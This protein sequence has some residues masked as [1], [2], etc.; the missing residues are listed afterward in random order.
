MPT[1]PGTPEL[2]PTERT[3]V[4]RKRERGSYDVETIHAILDEGMVCHVGFA[5]DGHPW[6]IPTAYARIGDYVYLHGATA[7]N[8]LRTLA[9]GGSACVTVTLIDGLVLARSTFHH[10]VNYRSVVLF[11]VAE[12][13]EDE[14]E[15]ATA[16][17]AFVEH[18]VPGRTSEAR[19]PTPSELRST[20]VVRI[21]IDEAS[22]KVRT[23]GPIDDEP[24]MDLPVWAG[25]IPLATTAGAPIADDDLPPDVAV[26]PYASNYTRRGSTD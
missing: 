8:A 5:V 14:R 4:R 26:P 15:K 11:G 16:L 13:V 3:T 20:L 1:G 24:D 17:D 23:G 2:A 9:E 18:L 25:V 7:N 12:R 22:A 6:V 21:P 19:V 10:S